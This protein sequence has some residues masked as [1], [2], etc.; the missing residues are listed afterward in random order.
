[1][2]WAFLILALLA[3]VVTVALLAVGLGAFAALWLVVALGWFA[4]SM[5][6]R[7]LDARGY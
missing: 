7:H 4:I 1:L 2:W 5:W 3:L 6:R